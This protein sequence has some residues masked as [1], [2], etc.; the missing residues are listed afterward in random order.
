MS[1]REPLFNSAPTH[2]CFVSLTRPPL[3]AQ[4]SEK[5]R[6]QLDV[7]LL[8]TSQRNAAGSMR[9]GMTDKISLPTL[10]EMA[11]TG[12]AGEM[13]TGT[14]GVVRRSGQRLLIRLWVTLSGDAPE[15][16][17]HCPRDLISR[18]VESHLLQKP[19]QRM[20]R[21][22]CWPSPAPSPSFQEGTWCGSP[23]FCHR[24][25]CLHT[26]YDSL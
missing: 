13:H 5:V 18:A 20:A 6:F 8:Q 24:H 4:G 26:L 3:P 22:V 21:L 7:F 16:V 10:K 25:A 15:A 19:V 1:F 9:A 2:C 11:A 23:P 17:A 12:E 14:N